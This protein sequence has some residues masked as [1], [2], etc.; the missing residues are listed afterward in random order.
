MSAIDTAVI[1][2]FQDHIISKLLSEPLLQ[3]VPIVEMR[4]Q[5]RLDVAQRT[6]PHLAG[7]NGKVG[8][9]ILV[10]LPLMDPAVDDD[11]PGMQADVLLY[12]DITSKDDINLVNSNGANLSAE[13]VLTIVWLLVNQWS[14]TGIGSGA[15]YVD[16]ADPIEDKK[17]AYG[18]RLAVRMRTAQDQPTKT[19]APTASFS[20]GRCTLHV[21]ASGATIYYT[22]DGSMPGPWT[23]NPGGTANTSTVYSSPFTV[24]SGTVI[25]AAAFVLNSTST[26]GSDVRQYTAP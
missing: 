17:G 26:I 12:L 20:G 3:Y 5:I 14:N 19:D 16:G 18:Y 23:A 2:R 6:A 13:D 21:N 22:T 8:V 4:R 9:G 25:L 24:A 11:I 1:R 15:I 10:N 7:R